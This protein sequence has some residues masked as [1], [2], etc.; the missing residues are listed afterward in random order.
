MYGVARV[1][2]VFHNLDRMEVINCTIGTK[3]TAI[4]SVILLMQLFGNY[5]GPLFSTHYEIY[6]E[7]QINTYL[8]PVTWFISWEESRYV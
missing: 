6:F 3:S 2:H 4:K 5:S 7:D 1:K 8:G